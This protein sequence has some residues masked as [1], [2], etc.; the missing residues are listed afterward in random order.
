MRY[1]NG[2]NA[3]ANMHTETPTEP[4]HNMKDIEFNINELYNEQTMPL[5][6]PAFFGDNDP[7]W[8]IRV[9]KGKELASNGK[10]K[11]QEALAGCEEVYR[12]NNYYYSETLDLKKTEP[13]VTN[14]G[15]SR[16]NVGKIVDQEGRL[17]NT[18]SDCAA[19]AGV[20]V[21]MVVYDTKELDVDDK[22]NGNVKLHRFMDQNLLCISLLPTS[23]NM[24]WGSEGNCNVKRYDFDTPGEFANMVRDINGW[25]NTRTLKDE[26]GHDHPAAKMVWNNYWGDIHPWLGG[27]TNSNTSD[28]V[29]EWFIPSPAEWRLFLKG[30]HA[31]VCSYD[32]TQVAD[33]IK[34][35]YKQAGIEPLNEVSIFGVEYKGLSLMPLDGNFWTST[36]AN[37][38]QAYT[39]HIDGQYGARFEKNEKG[40]AYRIFPFVIMRERK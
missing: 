35:V 28:W 18:I 13:V 12:Y 40:N 5:R 20:P 24:A 36:D 3:A 2:I 33:H 11:E 22:A 1:S 26:T 17:Y 19:R 29:T 10:E 30:M 37:D 31:W 38:K 14:S 34:A 39:M 8:I 4:G 7:R 9:A 16:S 21:A 32:G 15:K 6:H 23:E 27:F 25:L